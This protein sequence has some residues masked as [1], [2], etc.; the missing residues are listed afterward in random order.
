MKRSS[1]FILCSLVFS[2][3]AV[4]MMSSPAV[5]GLNA[6]GPVPIPGNLFPVLNGSTAPIISGSGVSTSQST[7]IMPSISTKSLS[8]VTTSII[9]S[10]YSVNKVQSGL[11]ASDPLNKNIDQSHL[12]AN[13]GY[14]TFGGDAPA[15]HAHYSVNE[16]SHGLHIGVQAPAT[17]VWAGFYAASPNT[18][19]ALFHSVITAPVR[20]I[21]QQYFENGLYIQT[22]QSFINYVTCVSVT[23]SSGTV[24]AVVSTT[25]DATQATQF[26]VLYVNGSANQPL[27]RDCTIITNGDNYLKVYLDHVMVYS[28]N[29]MNLQMPS[30]FNSYLEPQT[31]FHDKLLKGTHKD[32]Y[33][34]SDENIKV[35]NNPPLAATVRLVDSLGNVLASSPVTLGN[36]TLDVGKYHFPISGNINVY[37]SND[38]IMASSPASVYGGDVF[39]VTTSSSVGP[40]AP[41]PPTNLS[42]IAAST[43]QINLS[44][45]APT[46]NGGSPVTGYKIER[47]TDGGSTWNTIVSKTS[48]AETKYSNTGLAS[49]TTYTYRVSAINVI[50]TSSPSNTASATTSGTTQVTI[51]VQSV[52]LSGNTIT[53]LYTTLQS[54]GKTIKTG[55]TTMNYIVTAGTQYTATVS[56]YQNYV[57]DHWADGSTDP[58][59]TVTPTQSITLVAYYKT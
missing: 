55:Y 29:A 38:S 31:S 41:Q 20:T 15:E 44:W 52:D 27:T 12:L 4:P 9:S 46:N 48:N 33:A 6:T 25:G 34:T 5:E 26:N 59:I 18:N 56:N 54:A 40:S 57:F 17:G 8:T 22:S 28:N 16:D 49:G 30:P 50:G 23:S 43:S 2:I 21:P 14:W 3:L 45:T 35:T 11:V 58:F 47:S 32:Y 51:T 7:S 39:T 10:S 19:A 13:T 53:G 1:S 42:A 24:W 36:A 37:D